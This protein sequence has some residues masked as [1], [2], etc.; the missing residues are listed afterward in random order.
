[1]GWAGPAAV[2][3]AL[4]AGGA[5]GATAAEPP[6]AVDAVSPTAA[7]AAPRRPQRLSQWLLERGARADDYLLGTLWRVDDEVPRQQALRLEVRADLMQLATLSETITSSI[8][9]IVAVSRQS[10]QGAGEVSKAVGDLAGQMSDI[11]SLVDTFRV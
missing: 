4:A 3:L 1:M 5:G 7:P 9:Q 2:A 8:Q 6:Q 11:K 10:A